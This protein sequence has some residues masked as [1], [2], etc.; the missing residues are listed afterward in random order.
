MEGH[1][2]SAGSGRRGIENRDSGGVE[3]W[4]GIEIVEETRGIEI[5]EERRGIEIVEEPRGIDIAEG[6]EGH[7]DS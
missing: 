6:V 3:E 4:R 5:V 2:D 7:K 1:R